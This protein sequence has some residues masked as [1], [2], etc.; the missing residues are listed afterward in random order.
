MAEA[1][2]PLAVHPERSLDPGN[3]TQ[4]LL[5]QESPGYYNPIDICNYALPLPGWILPFT[6]LIESEKPDLLKEAEKERPTK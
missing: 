5:L 3:S 6:W 4:G 2:T 1:A